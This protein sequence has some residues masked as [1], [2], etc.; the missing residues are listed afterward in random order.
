MKKVLFLVN[1]DVAIYNFRLELVQRLIEE[2]Y[3]VVV[4]SP[5]GERIEDLKKLGCVFIDTKINRRNMNPITDLLLLRF[6]LHVL[7]RI[8]PDIV[9]SYTIKPNIYGGMACEY[10]NIPYIA[11]ITGLGTAMEQGGWL[12]IL[13]IILYKAAFMKVTRVFFQNNENMQFFSNHGIARGRHMLIPGSGVNL[14][15]FIPLEYPSSDTIEFTFIS[16]IMKEKGI[17]QFL[18]AAI[19][20]KAKYPNTKFHVCGFCEE[21]YKPKLLKLQNIGI[22]IYHGMLSDVRDILG[23]VHCTV[24]PTYYPEGLSN[25]LL[26]SCACARPIITTDRSGCKE[27]IDDGE[28]GY[29][30]RQKDGGDLV[31]K[32][33]RFILLPYEQKRLMGLNG[34]KKVEIKFDR[35]FIVNSYMAEISECMNGLGDHKR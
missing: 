3:Q 12:S 14:Q 8:K 30:V 20:I 7:E 11:N 2:G 13:T 28:N 25:V 23:K 27:V 5:Y 22:I 9:L 17:D 32:I 34:R 26:E 18:D 6:Y 35:K 1:H 10:Y 21:D 15:H 19:A 33:E 16:R 24:H 4:S 29:I 31:A